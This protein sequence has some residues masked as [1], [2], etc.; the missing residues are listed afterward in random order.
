MKVSI[1]LRRLKSILP[2]EITPTEMGIID[3]N[4]AWLGVPTL[5]LMEN[6]GRSVVYALKKKF[7]KLEEKKIFIFA[8]TGN[9]GGDSF[10]IARHLAHEN[11]QVTVFL[12]G[13]AQ[14]IRTEISRKNWDIL[15]WMK[16]S[17]ELYEIPDSSSLSIIKDKMEQPPEILI[18]GLLGTGIRGL[19]REPVSTVIDLINA[20][21]AFKVSVDVPSG[22]DPLT[23]KVLDK[24]VTP[25][26]TVTFHKN[27]V[28]LKSEQLTGEIVIS[29]I[30]V[31]PEAEL[32]VGKGDLN[33][34]QLNRPRESHKGDFGKVLVV[35]G[36]AHYSGAPALV[37]LASYR[38]G[39]DLV[40]LL[41]PSVIAPSIRSFSPD[42]IVRSYPE[43]F[44]TEEMVEIARELLDWSTVVAIGPGLGPLEKTKKGTLE[45]I[46]EIVKK[47]IPMVIDADALKALQG[48]LEMIKGTRTILTP[49][50]GEYQILTSQE[51]K[52][53]PTLLEKI[54]N[55]E[56]FAADYDLT[57]L[58]K[59][60]EDVISDGKRIKINWTGTPAMTVGGTGDVLTGICSALIANNKISPFDAACCGAFINGRAGEFAIGDLAGNHLLATDLIE[61]IPQAM[62]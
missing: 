24:A 28:G 5:L 12:L 25:D 21:K 62:R 4:S 16:Y 41:V 20:T 19:I 7:K 2:K 30:G 13:A 9:N 54:K 46:R 42:L 6:A 29:S 43:D 31:P 51:F 17:V 53:S 33:A 36:S 15:R 3:Q 44:F 59:G 18:D 10:V 14:S 26:M 35:G 11:A 50:F 39:V 55:V 34:L 49:H 32:V 61:Y 52:T 48:E 56:K 40:K 45:L 58:L 57:I 60:P 23:G 1:E 8:G 38:T 27:K 47:R 22:V 37:A